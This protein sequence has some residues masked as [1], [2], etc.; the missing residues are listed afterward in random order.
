VVGSR[1]VTTFDLTVYDDSGCYAD[2][3]GPVTVQVQPR[4]R[5]RLLVLI[6]TYSNQNLY[7]CSLYLVKSNY[8]GVSRCGKYTVPDQN[9][10]P[11]QI[12]QAGLAFD[13]SLTVTDTNSHG[14]AGSPGLGATDQT[15]VLTD[16]YASGA[17]GGPLS[18]ESYTYVLQ[19]ITYHLTGK[20][21]RTN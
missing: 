15:Y 2:G 17:A 4:S 9:T 7:N 8:Y 6:T 13:E 18:P 21:V 14:T 11:T 12:Q 3:Q 1:N 5:G 19:T 16:F 20:T 10:P